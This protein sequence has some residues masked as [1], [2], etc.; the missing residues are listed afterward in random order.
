M[1]GRLIDPFL[2]ELA[3]LDT[4]ATAEDPDDTGPLESGY[5]D[6]FKEPVVITDTGGDRVSARKEKAAIKI[7]AQVELGY[8]NTDVIR[9]VLG[10]DSPDTKT[11]VVFHFADLER[12]GLVDAATGEAM[13]RKGDRLVA[14]YRMNGTLV[15]TIRTPPGL[16]ATSVAPSSFGIGLDRNLLLVT[17]EEREQGVQGQ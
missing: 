5:D 4:A 3:Q 8:M 12:L 2:V 1:R 6:D 13:I 14:I 10:G 17:F 7:P 16:Y 11:I 15:Q 9:P